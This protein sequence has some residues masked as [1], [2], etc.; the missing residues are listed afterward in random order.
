MAINYELDLS[1]FS[2][3]KFKSQIESRGLHPSRRI[4]FEGL[5]EKIQMLANIGIYNLSLLV[6]ALKSKNSI[7][8]ISEQTGISNEYLIMLNREAKSYITK[9]VSLNKFPDVET[10]T[11]NQLAKFGIKS[12]K[13]LFTK[14]V[15]LGISKAA[16]EWDISEDAVLE[17][18]CMCDLVRIWGVGPVFARIVLETGITSVKQFIELDPILGYKQFIDTNKK[19]NYTKAIFIDSDIVYCH[20]M[21]KELTVLDFDTII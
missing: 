18:I 17:L 14:T 11:I 7:Q 10:V 5:S 16:K 2:I 12:S 15:V 6:K 21:A 19:G 3:D 13:S 9:S 4:L 1:E 20:I 8:L